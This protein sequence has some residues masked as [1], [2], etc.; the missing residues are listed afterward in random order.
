MEKYKNLADALNLDKE[1]IPRARRFFKNLPEIE[2]LL[3]TGITIKSLVN[4]LNANGFEIEFKTFEGELYRARKKQKKLSDIKND[5]TPKEKHKEYSLSENKAEMPKVEIPATEQSLRE[6]REKPITQKTLAEIRAETDA[7][8][9][10]SQA[11]PSAAVQKR[12]DKLKKENA[13]RLE[14]ERRKNDAHSD[15]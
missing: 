10:E 8:F 1:R 3:K 7:F 5:N 4:D 14:R 13:E 15:S 9:K 6:K 12:I 2:S 11:K